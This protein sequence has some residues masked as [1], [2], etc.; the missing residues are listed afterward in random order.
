MKVNAKMLIEKGARWDCGDFDKYLKKFGN[1]G[2]SL[3][4]F[5]EWAINHCEGVNY[6][7]VLENFPLPK[8]EK[9]FSVGDVI[10]TNIGCTCLIIENDGDYV[11]LLNIKEHWLMSM[12]FGEKKFKVGYVK[13]ITIKELMSMGFKKDVKKVGRG[14]ITVEE[15]V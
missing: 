12:D 13:K 3:E 11:S 7:W 5:H 4:R 6:G 8:E 14:K 2:I 9:T 1:E 15:C 10:E